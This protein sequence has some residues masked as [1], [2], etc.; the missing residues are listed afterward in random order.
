MKAAEGKNA[1]AMFNVGNCYLYGYGTASDKTKA[2][3]W[4]Q[5]AAK[6]GNPKAQ[7]ALQKLHDATSGEK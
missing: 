2:A 6:R 1:T 3:H 5:E 4:F 7:A